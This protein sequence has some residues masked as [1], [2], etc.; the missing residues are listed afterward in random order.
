M[1]KKTSIWVTFQREGFHN[2]PAAKDIEGVE[3]LAHRHRHLFKFKVQIQVFKNDRDIEFILFKRWLEAGFADGAVELDNKSCEMVSD[4]LH[5][6]IVKK[7]PGRDIS[8]DVSEDGENG[9]HTE[10]L[11]VDIL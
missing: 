5:A 8:I 7:Y 2:Y 6:M 4:E 1:L 10:Y 3:F 11:G 9:S